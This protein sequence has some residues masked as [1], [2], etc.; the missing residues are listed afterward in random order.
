MFCLRRTWR[1]R[2][3][4]RAGGKL[5]TGIA[6]L[7]LSFIPLAVGLGF[8]Y[9]MEYEFFGFLSFPI[10]QKLSLLAESFLFPLEVGSYVP[11][12]ALIISGIVGGLIFRSI[13]KPLLI[14]F[15]FAWIIA[16][17]GGGFA[18]QAM[19]FLPSSLV[20][21]T[22]LI[23]QIV[24]IIDFCCGVWFGILAGSTIHGR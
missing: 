1:L 11:W 12:V 9:F 19:G 20:F 18:L 22:I 4:K 5:A 13:L 10:T 14:T 8:V 3:V 2:R 15:G 6:W 23:N 7:V 21:R 24:A 16:Y 17:A